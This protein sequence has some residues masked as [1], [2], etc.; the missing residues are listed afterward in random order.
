[1]FDAELSRAGSTKTTGIFLHMVGNILK[2][3]SSKGLFAAVDWNCDE[4]SGTNLAQSLKFLEKHYLKLFLWRR[5]IQVWTTAA[6]FSGWPCEKPIYLVSKPT[7]F[8]PKFSVDTWSAVLTTATQK[9]PLEV[10][11][12]AMV[13]LF[14]L[15]LWSSERV[16]C[17]FVETTL[18]VLPQN[19]KCKNSFVEILT[20]RDCRHAE[21]S[22]DKGN[23]HV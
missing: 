20:E 2:L 10:W 19:A 12:I 6:D 5:S 13:H 11:K 14:F 18:N 8:R 17:G 16:T 15:Q 23:R 21:I 4:T 3:P 22:F 7:P 9:I 1:M